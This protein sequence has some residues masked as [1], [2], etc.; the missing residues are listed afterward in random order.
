TMYTI[1]SNCLNNPKLE[2]C[3]NNQDTLEQAIPINKQIN[4]T[5]N[6][7][8]SDAEV[9]F[10]GKIIKVVK[11]D[12]VPPISNTNL[13]VMND[14]TFAGEISNLIYLGRIFLDK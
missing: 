5:V 11:L 7:L 1:S 13:Y 3:D 8:G 2:N 10:D 12:G 9:Y 14:N 6:L 4:I